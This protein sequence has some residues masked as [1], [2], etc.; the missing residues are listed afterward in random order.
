MQVRVTD[1]AECTEATGWEARWIPAS[2]VV[3][4]RALEHEHEHEHEHECGV[5]AATACCPGINFFT[6]EAHAHAWV[7]AHPV[8]DGVLLTQVVAMRRAHVLY[9]GLFDRMGEDPR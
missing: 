9:R 7:E 4:A 5:D 2:T 3:Y 6:T 8:A 1:A